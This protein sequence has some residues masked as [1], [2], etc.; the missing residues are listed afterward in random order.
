MIRGTG[1]YSNVNVFNALAPDDE[2]TITVALPAAAGGVVQ[3]INDEVIMVDA[4]LWRPMTQV[5][6]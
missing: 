5:A 4:A 2:A 3:R 1:A 6:A